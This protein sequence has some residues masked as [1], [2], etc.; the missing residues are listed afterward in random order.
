MTWNDIFE[1]FVSCPKVSVS[2]IAYFFWPSTITVHICDKQE[3]VKTF[4]VFRMETFVVKMVFLKD[5]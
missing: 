5:R 1:A 2:G 4:L 3:Q